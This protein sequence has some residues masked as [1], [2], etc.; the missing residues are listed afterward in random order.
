MM[1][2]IWS[3]AKGTISCWFALADI[4][5]KSFSW[6]FFSPWSLARRNA[7]NI[8]QQVTDSKLLIIFNGFYLNK[9]VFPFVP[10]DLHLQ[11]F[12][13]SLE[14]VCLPFATSCATTS[15]RRSLAAKSQCERFSINK[16]GERRE[17]LP[18][19]QWTLQNLERLKLETSQFKNGSASN[20]QTWKLKNVRTTIRSLDPE[21]LIQVIIGTFQY[22]K[23]IDQNC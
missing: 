4:L 19:K 21:R 14:P 11:P 22:W 20:K 7:E 17:R 5:H 2:Y 8:R 3:L 23:V 6:F 16:T 13:T 10:F 18:T 15:C 12:S 1:I 9:L